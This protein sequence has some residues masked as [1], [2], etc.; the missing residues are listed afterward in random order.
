MTFTI[1]FQWWMIPILTIAVGFLISTIVA[2]NSSGGW[3]FD[4]N[5]ILAFFI[6]VGSIITAI[7]MV[8]GH[9]I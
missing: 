9:Y 4:W 6:G 7:S 3:L 5:D 1:T 2:G 8:I